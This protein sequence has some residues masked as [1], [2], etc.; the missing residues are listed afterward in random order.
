M[1]SNASQRALLY[2]RLQE[3]L[4]PEPASILM[5]HLPSIDDLATKSDVLALRSD[6]LALRSDVQDL[7]RRVDGLEQRM[8]GLDVRMERLEERMDSFHGA[9]RE[10]TRQFILAMVGTMASFAAVVIAAGILT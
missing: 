10:Q 7:A 1:T 5:Q 8:D 6:V 3:V 4:G 9:L 2:A